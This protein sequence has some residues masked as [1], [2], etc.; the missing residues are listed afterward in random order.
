MN[1]LGVHVVPKISCFLLH[2]HTHTHT[3]TLLEEMKLE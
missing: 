2:T 1:N 3:H